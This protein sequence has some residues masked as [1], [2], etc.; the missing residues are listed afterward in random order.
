MVQNN[1][2]LGKFRD[3]NPPIAVVEANGGFPDGET[4]E[5]GGIVQSGEKR[6]A[7]FVKST[8]SDPA[9]VRTTKAERT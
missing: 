2:S 5:D 7:G 9:R 1:H 4:C 6:T 8:V 3:R